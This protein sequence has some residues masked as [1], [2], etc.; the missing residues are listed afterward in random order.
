MYYECVHGLSVLGSLL[1]AGSMK[2]MA[3]RGNFESFE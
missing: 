1:A 2:G 3:R